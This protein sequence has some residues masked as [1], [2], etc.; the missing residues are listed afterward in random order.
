MNII[1]ILI[2][3]LYAYNAFPQHQYNIWH[4]GYSGYGITQWNFLVDT[5]SLSHH[6]GYHECFL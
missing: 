2:T 3:I 6:Y 1:H 4:T 5:L